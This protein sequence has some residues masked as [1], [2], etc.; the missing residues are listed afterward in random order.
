[1][2]QQFHVTEKGMTADA[3]NKTKSLALM[4]EGLERAER[5]FRELFERRPTD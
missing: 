4:P 2:K 3:R 5:I 1:V